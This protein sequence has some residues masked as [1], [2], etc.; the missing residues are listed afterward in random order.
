MALFCPRCRNSLCIHCISKRLLPAPLPARAHPNSTPTLWRCPALNPLYLGLSAGTLR[1]CFTPETGSFTDAEHHQ[2]RCR[3]PQ[4]PECPGATWI[5]HHWPQPTPH[6]AQKSFFKKREQTGICVLSGPVSWTIIPA[7]PSEVLQQESC[8]LP[9]PIRC[10]HWGTAARCSL[11]ESPQVKLEAPCAALVLWTGY[12]QQW[13]EAE[14]NYCH[15]NNAFLHV[16]M[17]SVIKSCLLLNLLTAAGKHPLTPD[18]GVNS[19]V[20]EA[21]LCFLRLQTSVLNVRNRTTLQHTQKKKSPKKLNY[22]LFV[23]TI[24]QHSQ[25]LRH[26]F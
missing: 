8:E 26:L 10:L 15:L 13:R 18:N 19:A 2:P 6:P 7:M 22:L 1:V 16:W 20:T 14:E 25:R 11:G 9:L 3:L 12:K 4:D 23:V 21:A 17:R 24:T 5:L